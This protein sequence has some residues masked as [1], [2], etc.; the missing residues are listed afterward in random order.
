M[1]FSDSI[2]FFKTFQIYMIVTS[3][4]L[5]MIVFRWSCVSGGKGS[6]VSLSCLL[7]HEDYKTSKIPRWSVTQVIVDK[8][9]WFSDYIFGSS[10]CMSCVF[11]S[12]SFQKTNLSK[13]GKLCQQLFA[14]FSESPQNM[15]FNDF[16]QDSWFIMTASL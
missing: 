15:N 7:L 3:Q 4:F 14:S 13:A 12:W 11:S 6:E 8:L 9:T 16:R 1:V 10:F 2:F 5:E